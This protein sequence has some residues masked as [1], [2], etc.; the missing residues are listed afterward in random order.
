MIGRN[1]LVELGIRLEINLPIG[2]NG[3]DKAKNLKFIHV[4]YFFQ[5]LCQ[6][7]KSAIS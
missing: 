2:E 3:R 6:T 1:V 7:K 5:D 4:P